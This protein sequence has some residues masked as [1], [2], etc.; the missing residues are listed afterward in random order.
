MAASEW[1][2]HLAKIKSFVETH[3]HSRVPKDYRDNEGAPLHILVDNVRWKHADRDW[4]EGH[5][6]NQ[7]EWFPGV[8]WESDL[9]GLDGW[10]WEIE[11]PSDIPVLRA[12]RRDAHSRKTS[13]RR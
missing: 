12:Q 3:G 6:P 5:R 13:V 8:D 11:Q 10:S 4:L 7:A 2:R 1:R 9:E